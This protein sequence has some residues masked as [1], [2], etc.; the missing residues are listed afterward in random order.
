MASLMAMKRS[1]NFSTPPPD[2]LSNRPEL[3]QLRAFLRAKAPQHL[4]IALT[5]VHRKT[6]GRCSAPALGRHPCRNNKSVEQ[7][8]APC[9]WPT[10][11]MDPSE[12]RGQTPLTRR[13]EPS[14]RAPRRRS[15]SRKI[16]RDTSE[17]Q[18]PCNIVCRLLLEKKN[19]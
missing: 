16:G 15:C 9:G 4:H 1:R 11:R 3:V 5:E 13:T 18:S 10:G 8:S 19:K 7:P 17:L 14:S 6:Y 12:D 2:F